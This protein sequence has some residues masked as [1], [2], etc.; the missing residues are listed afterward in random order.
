M[1]RKV[2]LKHSEEHIAEIVELW[3]KSF[4]ATEIGFKVE[5]TRNSVIGILHRYFR[6]HPEEENKKRIVKKGKFINRPIPTVAASRPQTVFRKAKI[7]LPLREE[8][9]NELTEGV[10][11]ID[12][13]YDSCRFVIGQGKHP[14]FCGKKSVF[15][16]SWCDEH[17]KVVF[18]PDRRK[19]WQNSLKR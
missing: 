18:I 8:P 7:L 3:N 2:T 10:S 6:R 19:E 5:A 12:L 13:K 14:V 11:L 15:N 16:K 9:V 4:S 17:Y 1:T